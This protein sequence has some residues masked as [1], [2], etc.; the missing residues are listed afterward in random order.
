V[1]VGALCT[2]LFTGSAD[3]REMAVRCNTTS[4]SRG[5]KPDT[6]VLDLTTCVALCDST[7]H[8]SY[9]HHPA[10]KRL[11]KQQSCQYERY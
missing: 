4:D 10:D 3:N 8:I 1:T 6:V 11:R 5:K 2:T 7:I 9:Y